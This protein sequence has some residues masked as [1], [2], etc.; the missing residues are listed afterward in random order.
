V[1]KHDKACI[2]KVTMDF[3]AEHYCKVDRLNDIQRLA[4][5]FTPLGI[6]P[7]LLPY[8]LEFKYIFG[9]FV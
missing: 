6:F 9:G 1:S 2:L 7:I 8:N 3:K 4:K 5:V